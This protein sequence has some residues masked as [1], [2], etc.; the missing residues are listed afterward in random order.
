MREDM[1]PLDAVRLEI[2]QQF[3]DVVGKR[4]GI[5]HIRIFPKSLQIERAAVEIPLKKTDL[6]GEHRAV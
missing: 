5:F 3:G 1:R 6:M 4:I 2:V